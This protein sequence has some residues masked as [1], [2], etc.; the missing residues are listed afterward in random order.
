MRV[1]DNICYINQ[2]FEHEKQ[3]LSNLGD[4]FPRQQIVEET[5]VSDKSL[6]TVLV[7]LHPDYL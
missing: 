2:E 4:Y 1:K 6:K 7:T 5:Q 3:Y